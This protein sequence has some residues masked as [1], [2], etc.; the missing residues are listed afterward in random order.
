MSE[1]SLA[2]APA[3]SS[4]EGF[5]VLQEPIADS[6]LANI[7][8]VHLTLDGDAS[9]L[10]DGAI[11]LG[12]V[13]KAGEIIACLAVSREAT[14]TLEVD[15]NL[16]TK[17]AYP[18]VALLSASAPLAFSANQVAEAVLTSWTVAIPA[19][20]ILEVKVNY[21]TPINAKV[22]DVYVVIQH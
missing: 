22:V 19:M 20:S 14:A 9:V 12:Y 11:G 17:A 18:T 4:R 2:L 6:K 21:T 3:D 15:L 1:I 13:H 8:V 5:I 10:I 16:G 7:E